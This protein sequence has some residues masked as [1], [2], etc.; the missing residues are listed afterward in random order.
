MMGLGDLVVQ[1]IGMAIGKLDLY[2]VA[3]GINPQRVLPIMIDVGTNNE[4]LL[5]DEWYLGLQE[6]RL[7]G[8]EYVS[9]IDELMEAL[10]TRWPNV[11]VQFE[12]FQSKWAL[13]LLERYRNVYR[14]FNDDI[15]G[16]AGVAIAGIL[17]TLRSQKRPITDFPKLK[18]VVAGAGK[19]GSSTMDRILE[20]SG[21]SASSSIKSKD[22]IWVVDADG[23]ITEERGNNVHPDVRP[24]MKKCGNRLTE[25]T[26]LA[27][28]VGEVQ[29][30]VLIGLSDSGGLF[31]IDWFWVV[32][33]LKLDCCWSR[34]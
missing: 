15:Q 1:G 10:F 24:F 21:S 5:E 14:M 29:P 30:D 26:N 8:D 12:G 22:Q 27:E 9:I 2:V 18:I 32:E 25:G 3:A 33:G 4:K 19:A 16:T 11:I 20:Q 13:K 7:D 28:V 6:R 17:G 34:G 31:T 23:L